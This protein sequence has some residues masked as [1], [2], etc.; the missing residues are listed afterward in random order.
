MLELKESHATTPFR[1]F[2]NTENHRQSF[3]SW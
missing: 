3:A 1:G 2:S